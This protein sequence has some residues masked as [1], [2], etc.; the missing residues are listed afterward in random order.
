MPR[1]IVTTSYTERPWLT[2]N[3]L[4]T[5]LLWKLLQENW[6]AILLEN[7]KS[8]PVYTTRTIPAT[9]YN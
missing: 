4:L 3:Y 9:I 5:E 2:L 7:S 8:A 6:W 1:P